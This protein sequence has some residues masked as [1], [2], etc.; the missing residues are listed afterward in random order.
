MYSVCEMLEQQTEMRSV[1]SLSL[2]FSSCN[3][4]AVLI[5]FGL[6]C[7]SILLA[8]ELITAEQPYHISYSFMTVKASLRDTS[9]VSR[10]YNWTLSLSLSSSFCAAVLSAA[11]IDWPGGNKAQGFVCLCVCTC[12]C[13]CIR[14]WHNTGPNVSGLRMVSCLALCVF[15]NPQPLPFPLSL[16]FCPLSFH[17]HSAPLS[18]SFPCM[19]LLPSPSLPLLFTETKLT[20][21]VWSSWP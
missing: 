18:S 3:L 5:M 14:Q 12:V 11:S 6:S 7:C 15:L 19:P 17:L 21:W 4:W 20:C 2:C 16:C 9:P 1:Q 10:L 8:Y 13:L